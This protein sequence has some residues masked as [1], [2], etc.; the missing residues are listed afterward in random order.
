MDGIRENVEDFL[1]IGYCGL[2]DIVVMVIQDGVDRMDK[3]L[4]QYLQD[5][6]IFDEQLIYSTRDYVDKHKK[7]V[8]SKHIMHVFELR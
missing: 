5:K 7:N 4:K 6:G 8:K 2:D 1:K 3:D